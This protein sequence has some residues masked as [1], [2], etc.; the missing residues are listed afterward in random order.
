MLFITDRRPALMSMDGWVELGEGVLAP[1]RR[2]L[3]RHHP[4]APL[5]KKKNI[6]VWSHEIYLIFLLVY[7]FLFLNLCNPSIVSCCVFCLYSIQFRSLIF[8][9]RFL[10]ERVGISFLLIDC[11]FLLAQWCWQI[12]RERQEPLQPPCNCKKSSK[13]WVVIN[14]EI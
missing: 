13:V 11:F 2:H 8:P 5:K 4:H 12:L 3:I 14:A 9:L 1:Y 10:C 7:N 6:L